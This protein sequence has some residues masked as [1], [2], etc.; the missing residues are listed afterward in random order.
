MGKVMSGSIL[1]ESSRDEGVGLIVVSAGA[2]FYAW[3]YVRVPHV[4]EKAPLD[5]AALEA[6]KQR[7]SG[8]RLNVYRRP[9][10]DRLRAE[11]DHA[12]PRRMA[13]VCASIGLIAFVAGVVLCLI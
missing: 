3:S 11:E 1:G 4:V 9:A 2:F 5:P 7:R 12:Y 10:I 6:L 8:T 13:K